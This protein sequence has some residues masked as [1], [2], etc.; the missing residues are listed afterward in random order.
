LADTQLDF[1]DLSWEE[2]GATVRTTLIALHKDVYGNG[3]PGL[4]AEMGE[5]LT[6]AKAAVAWMKGIASLLT[7][8]LLAFGTY[9]ALHH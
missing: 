5:V 6:Y 2:A 8:G 3:T 7:L 9:A 4:K 1:G